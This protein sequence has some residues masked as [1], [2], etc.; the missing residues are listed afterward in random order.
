MSKG[1]FLEY[2]SNQENKTVIL[3]LEGI[4]TLKMEIQNVIINY[5]EDYILLEN[6]ND[7]SSNIKFNLHQLMKI[8]KQINEE[9]CKI[10]LEFDQLQSVI[11]TIK[12]E[13]C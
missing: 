8:S 12:E 1:E 13:V 6:K 9:V 10:V 2:L 4:I 11:I 7:S 5:N 3:S